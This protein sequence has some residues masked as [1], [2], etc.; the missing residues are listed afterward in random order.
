MIV[1]TSQVY[2][3]YRGLLKTEGKWKLCKKIY[4]NILR[5]LEKAKHMAL[6]FLNQRML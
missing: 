6:K 1:Q 2:V 5:E 3:Q 4:C